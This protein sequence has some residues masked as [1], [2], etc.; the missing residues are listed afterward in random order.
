[1]KYG[2]ASSESAGQLTE[3]FDGKQA[4]GQVSYETKEL[5]SCPGS[6]YFS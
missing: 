5:L 1:L 3:N 6:S 4:A 2:G